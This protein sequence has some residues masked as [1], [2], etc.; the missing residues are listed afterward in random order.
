MIFMAGL[1]PIMI[2]HDGARF[3]EEKKAP[4]VGAMPG[5]IYSDSTLT[6]NNGQGFMLYTDGVNE[7]MNKDGEKFSNQRMIDEVSKDRDLP[8]EK[9]VHNLLDRIREHADSAAQF[10]D[11]AIMIIKFRK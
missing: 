1:V 6:L 11:I 5:I 10:D 9:I 8:S 3:I 2:N 4:P 7:A